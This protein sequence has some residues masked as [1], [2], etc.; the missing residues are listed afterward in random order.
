MNTR[1]SSLANQDP[2]LVEIPQGGSLSRADQFVPDGNIKHSAEMMRLMRHFDVARDAEYLAR[3]AAGQDPDQPESDKRKAKR[4][5]CIEDLIKRLVWLNRVDAQ[6]GKK[7]SRDL[8]GPDGERWITRREL[9]HLG[10]Q[11]TWGGKYS[12]DQMDAALAALARENIIERNKIYDPQKRTSRISIRLCPTEIMMILANR[13]QA[14][15]F[16]REKKSRKSFA[17]TIATDQIFLKSDSDWVRAINVGERIRAASSELYYEAALH[18][19]LLPMVACLKGLPSQ[20]ASRAD[21]RQNSVDSTLLSFLKMLLQKW[22]VNPENHEFRRRPIAFTRDAWRA[23]SHEE[24]QAA[25][26]TEA[27]IIRC[28]APLVASGILEWINLRSPGKGQP[29]IYMR[30]RVDLILAWFRDFERSGRFSPLPTGENKDWI[31]SVIDP[32]SIDYL[33]KDDVGGEVVTGQV[34]NAE[35]KLYPAAAGHDFLKNLEDYSTRCRAAFLKPPRASGDAFFQAITRLF[36]ETFSDYFAHPENPFDH[37]LVAQLRTLVNRGAIAH[38][39]TLQDLIHWQQA[40]NLGLSGLDDEWKLLQTPSDPAAMAR[41]LQHW[42]GIKRV[43]ELFFSSEVC[44]PWELAKAVKCWGN[45]LL[46]LYVSKSDSLDFESASERQIIASYFDRE[47]LE[48][49]NQLKSGSVYAPFS[50]DRLLAHLVA[51]YEIGLSE[52]LADFIRRDH[53]RLRLA[54]VENYRWALSMLKNFPGLMQQLNL[55]PAHWDHLRAKNAQQ[56]HNIQIRHE[57]TRLRTNAIDE[58]NYVWRVD[59]NDQ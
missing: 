50:Q 17:P 7:Q 29:R 31:P 44:F 1:E 12:E 42:S 23:F 25:G 27:Q 32:Q 39:M 28:K 49:Q 59:E 26:F 40:R 10:G 22:R 5:A 2:S 53:E 46:S 51:L 56:Y 34:H 47:K 9:E 20:V 43:L 38:R 52:H 37:K 15:M 11:R 33:I 57:Q 19:N 58:V 45:D 30:L 21:R 35:D 54:T 14:R 4:P 8:F 13:K 41:M 16:S 6:L 55:P 24:L 18:K 48:I 3:V 36:A